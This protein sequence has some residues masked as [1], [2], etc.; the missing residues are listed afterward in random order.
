VED[1]TCPGD[2]Q[3]QATLALTMTGQSQEC[4]VSVQNTDTSNAVGTWTELSQG[5][6]LGEMPSLGGAC[7]GQM[8]ATN[9]IRI[10]WSCPACQFVVME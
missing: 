9:A 1:S 8:L 6:F 4:V 10:V 7:L 2:P 3:S 5:V